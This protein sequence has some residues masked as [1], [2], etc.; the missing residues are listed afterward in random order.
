M[1]GEHGVTCNVEIE[2]AGEIAGATLRAEARGG[3]QCA[4]LLHA[5][6]ADRRMWRDVMAFLARDHLAVA[7]DQRGF[8]ETRSLDEPF[9]HI[10]DLGRVIEHFGCE[11]PILIGCSQGG[12]I[13]IDF[14]L[15]HPG[16]VAALVLVA[17]AVNGAPAP[18]E[19]P[20]GIAGL[21][22]DLDVAEA[23]GDIEQVNRIEAHLW[24]DGP[25]SVEGRITGK[26]RR[27]FLD[28]NGRALRHAPLTMER[29]CPP[30]LERVRAIQV[31]TLV[32][33]GDLDFPHLQR[34]SRWLA[35]TI[36]EARSL[37]MER[38][39]HLPNLEQPRRFNRAIEEFL[40]RE[41]RIR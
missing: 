28:M 4:I 23:K 34:L 25:M 29:P 7:Y 22:A 1:T 33:W 16:K 18:D 11:R 35:Y 31:P 13:A 20:P 19:Y 9:R 15:A 10:D 38:C 27:L 17:T 24:L 39:A 41:R 14:A 8:G 40:A 5:G 36:P 12:R 37:V 21:L 26:A 3:G 2:I 30:A 32:I 6:I